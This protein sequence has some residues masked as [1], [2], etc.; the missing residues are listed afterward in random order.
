MEPHLQLERRR[1][2]LDLSRD[3]VARLSGLTVYE[4]PHLEE[5]KD[6]IY[7]VSS[8]SDVARV[9]AVLGLDIVELFGL[10]PCHEQVSK[11]FV[12]KKREEIGLSPSDVAEQVGIEQAMLEDVER[13]LSAI[14]NWVMEPISRLA[15][16]LRV[17][18]A[19]LI[20]PMR[21]K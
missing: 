21:P 4:Y 15:R 5:D 10:D 14:G 7:M 8:L 16:I 13:D 11:E 2:E 17:S 3:D 1:Q 19:C 18:T 6:E 20:A 9:C 12:M